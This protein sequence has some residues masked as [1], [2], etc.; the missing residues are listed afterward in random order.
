M[1][2]SA[3]LQVESCGFPTGQ[4]KNTKHTGRS[5]HGPPGTGDL[6]VG[7]RGA[8]GAEGGAAGGSDAAGGADDAGRTAPVDAVLRTVRSLRAGSTLARIFVREEACERVRG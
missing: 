8:G 6:C 1:S 3:F 2:H 4:F 5:A 7:A